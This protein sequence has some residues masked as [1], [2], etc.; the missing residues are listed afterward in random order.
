[1]TTLD[2]IVCPRRDELIRAIP[3]FTPIQPLQRPRLNFYTKSIYQPIKN[4]QDLFSELKNHKTGKGEEIVTPCIVDTFIYYR[5]EGKSK[6]PITKKYGDEDNLRK[7]INDALVRFGII[8]DD[9]LIVGGENYKMFSDDDYAFVYIW[10]IADQPEHR[11]I[12][13]L[14]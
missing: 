6:Y 8:H 3:L 1:M 4:Q 11:S 7:A 10:S 14:V 2:V 13:H 12:R 9:R 5:K